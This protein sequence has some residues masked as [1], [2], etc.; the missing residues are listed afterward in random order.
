MEKAVISGERRCSFF[1]ELVQVVEGWDGDVNGTQAYVFREYLLVVLKIRS[2]QKEG[3]ALPCKLAVHANEVADRLAGAGARLD[4]VEDIYVPGVGVSS[5]L[6]VGDRGNRRYVSHSL[7]DR[8]FEEARVKI[9]ELRQQ[10]VAAQ[11]HPLI[12]GVHGYYHYT[13]GV[14]SLES[15]RRFMEKMCGEFKSREGLRWQG[16]VKCGIGG[17]VRVHVHYGW[18][19]RMMRALSNSEDVREEYNEGGDQV[20]CIRCIRAREYEWG[21]IVACLKVA[22][23]G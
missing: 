3:E 16:M 14:W 17:M 11:L 6:R 22:F 19:A 4:G 8:G 7:R 20:R 2:H 18:V 15:V 13:G 12:G 10:G 23:V 1:E 9:S 21:Y 5:I